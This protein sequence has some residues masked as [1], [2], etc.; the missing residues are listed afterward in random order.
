[1]LVVQNLTNRQLKFQGK[2][3]EPYGTAEYAVLKDFID[4]ARLFNA[5]KVTYRNVK[6][7]AVPKEE[8]AVEPKVEEP[9]KVEPVPEEVEKVEEPVVEEKTVDEPVVEEVKEPEQET[10]EPEVIEPV[11][12][13]EPEVVDKPKTSKRSKK[14][15]E[16]K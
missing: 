1:M 12:E 2:T 7:V 15:K 4:L 9:V 5:G 16:D 6:V 11:K 3:I 14:S 8:V 10:T 13:E